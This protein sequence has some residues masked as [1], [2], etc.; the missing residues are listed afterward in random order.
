MLDPRRLLTFGE[1]ARRGSF[2]RAAEALALTQP[3]V[4]QQVAAL[5]RQLGVQLLDRGPG[6]P[7]SPRPARCCSRTPTRS[8]AGWRRPTPRSP[9]SRAR[10]A[11][12]CG[13]AHSRA[14]WPPSSPPRSRACTPSGRTCGRGR[15]GHGARERRRGRRGR[16]APGDLL[17]RRD[18]AA[19]RARR[20]RTPRAG[21]GVDARRCRERPRARAAPADPARRARGRALDRPVAQRHDRPRV[22]GRGLRAADRLRHARPAGDRR[23][24]RRGTGGVARAT[25]ARGPAARRHARP[26]LGPRAAARAV[27]AHPRLRHAAGGAAFIAALSGT[28]AGP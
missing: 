20:H 6:G 10:R 13:S 8:P 3:A 11:R 4:S 15:R 18:H 26:R 7:T 16:A 25:P 19:V 27:R 21:R 9:S 24:D 1:V 23:A 17:R 14:R 12:R 2:S 22:P 5:E 28:P